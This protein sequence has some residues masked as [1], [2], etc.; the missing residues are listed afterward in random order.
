VV[1][2]FADI[3]AHRHALDVLRASEEKYR[4]LVESLPLMLIQSDLDG[5]IVYLNPTTQA[6]TGYDLDELRE[7]ASWQ[8]LVHPEDLPRLQTLKQEAQAGQTVRGEIR[9]RAKDGADK[10]CFAILQPRWQD[11][12][13]AGVTALAVDVTLQRRLEQELQRAQRLELV[14][15]LASGIAH[16]FNN[17]LTVVLTLTDLARVNLPEQH[18]VR[19]DLRRIADAGE[20]AAR[21]AGQLLAFSKQRRLVARPTPINPVVRRTLELVQTSLPGT[22]TVEPVL[23][24]EA[25]CVQADETQ[26]QQ[27]LMNLCLNARDAMPRGGRLVVQTRAAESAEWKVLSTESE[28]ADSALSTRHSALGTRREEDWVRLSVWDT[29][30]GMDAKV[31]ARIFDPFFSTKEHGTGLGLAV[32]Q[33]IVESYGGRIEVWSQPQE[34]TRFEIWLPRSQEVLSAPTGSG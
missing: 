14:G 17:L 28:A 34:G 10:V 3:T 20:Q 18:P 13:V 31:R 5:R 29:G 15:R 1:T 19:E 16:D 32:V 2:T 23:G 25:L 33:Q 7:P 22:I 11:G 8:A 21:L 30:H 12:A 4:G 26:L 24:D 9:Y 27:V 6:V